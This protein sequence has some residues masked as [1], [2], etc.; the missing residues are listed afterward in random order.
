MLSAFCFCGE[1]DAEAEQAVA[2]APSGVQT[3]LLLAMH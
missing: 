2:L 3:Q 1:G